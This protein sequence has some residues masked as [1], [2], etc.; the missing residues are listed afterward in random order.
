MS[1][2]MKRISSLEVIAT[3]NIDISDCRDSLHNYEEITEKNRQTQ[4]SR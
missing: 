2:I 3:W 4:F 1:Y